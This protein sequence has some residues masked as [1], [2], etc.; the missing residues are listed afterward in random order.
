MLIQNAP[1]NL[2]ATGVALSLIYMNPKARNEVFQA[3]QQ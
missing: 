3:Q 2:F 1:L